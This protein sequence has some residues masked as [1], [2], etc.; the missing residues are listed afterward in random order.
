MARSHSDAWRRCREQFVVELKSNI[1]GVNKATEAILINATKS[2]VDDM[3]PGI[4]SFGYI[5]IWSGNLYDSIGAT[6]SKSGR[7]VR[8]VYTNPV[9]KSPQDHAERKRIWGRNEIVEMIRSTPSPARGVSSTLFVA[10]PYAQDVDTGAVGVKP[11]NIGY[12]D[13]L[14]LAFEDKMTRAAEQLKWYNNK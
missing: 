9:A 6:V 4:N 11:E 13:S 1:K 7:I 8:A 14:R 3:Q 2:F 10:V 5:P 12:L